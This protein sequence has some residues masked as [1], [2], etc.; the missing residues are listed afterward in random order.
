M[1]RYLFTA[2]IRA[3]GSSKFGKNNKWGYFPA[4][5]AAWRLSEET[6]IK[7][8]GIFSDLKLRI[9]YGLA[10]NNRI[11]NYQS[12]AIMSSVT[13]ASGNGAQAG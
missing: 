3:D 5:S 4:V 6:F 1:N 10:G 7:N 13:A 9:G 11:N 2:S 12:L 8:I